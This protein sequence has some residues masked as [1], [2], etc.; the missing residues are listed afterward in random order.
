MRTIAALAIAS[1][2][3]HASPAVADE[4]LLLKVG[5]V[6]TCESESVVVWQHGTLLSKDKSK[7]P[8]HLFKKVPH[9]ECKEQTDFSVKDF[10]IKDMR[11]QHGNV[12]LMENRLEEKERKIEHVC[13]ETAISS[14]GDKIDIFSCRD[15][16]EYI[17]IVLPRYMIVRSHYSVEE[18]SKDIKLA[19]YSE[20]GNYHLEP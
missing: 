15:D 7:Y 1:T 5:S 4:D 14:Q 2:W 10:R 20:T 13:E 9:N 17:Y 11:H 16:Y 12:C 8:K 3:A 6:L 19:D 18:I